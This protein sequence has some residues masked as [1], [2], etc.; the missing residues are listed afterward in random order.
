MEYKKN[1]KVQFYNIDLCFFKKN[2]FFMKSRCLHGFFHD[3]VVFNILRIW[4]LFS[5]NDIDLN[6]LNSLGELCSQSLL[7]SFSFKHDQRTLI[8][9][10]LEKKELR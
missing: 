4:F 2:T 7:C 5:V 9:A 6:P 10:K 3:F 1:M 8:N